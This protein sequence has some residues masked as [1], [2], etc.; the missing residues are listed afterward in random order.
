MSEPVELTIVLLAVGVLVLVGVGIREALRSRFV[1]QIRAYSIEEVSRNN[2]GAIRSQIL[3][4]EREGL[5]DLRNDEMLQ[6][7]YG[8]STR[9]M[10]SPRDSFESAKLTTGEFNEP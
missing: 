7:V 1:R 8:L 10:R 6:A 5:I 4:Y 3:D 9:I 2:F